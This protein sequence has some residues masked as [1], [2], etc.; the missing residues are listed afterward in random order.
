MD[1]INNGNEESWRH[2]TFYKNCVEEPKTQ[3][4][5]NSKPIN[6]TFYL[7]YG[8]LRKDHLDWLTDFIN[9]HEKFKG[10]LDYNLKVLLPE[11]LIKLAQVTFNCNR[12]EVEFYL[13][14]MVA[15]TDCH[16]IFS[17]RLVPN[18]SESWY[19]NGKYFLAIETRNSYS[20]CKNFIF[21]Q[22]KLS[23]IT[24]QIRCNKVNVCKL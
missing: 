21:C 10:C 1:N 13:N 18:S 5:K 20:F 24:Y 15:G 19:E 23:G 12:L 22:C 16:K 17:K 7:D 14:G 9:R 2:Y 6:L 3:K 8:V 11:A 4:N